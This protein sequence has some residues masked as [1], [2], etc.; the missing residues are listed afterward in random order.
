MIAFSRLEEE[1][2]ALFSGLWRN[3]VFLVGKK[4]SGGALQGGP[5]IS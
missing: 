2:E 3:V 5:G 4:D 1:V